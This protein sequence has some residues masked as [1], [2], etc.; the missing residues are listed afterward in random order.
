MISSI[1]GATGAVSEN[2]ELV[3][4]GFGQEVLTCPTAMGGKDWDAGAYSP[5]TNM[6]Y[7]PLR[8]ACA[9]MAPLDD[10]GRSLYSLSMR[11]E[12]APGAD[13]LGGGV[14]D[15]RGDRRDGVDL[16]AARGDDVLPSRL[17]AAGSLRPRTAGRA[18]WQT[19]GR[20]LGSDPGAAHGQ[21]HHR[22]L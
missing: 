18:A 21:E 11:D 16:R 5:L 14:G 1:D 9:R 20:V 6:M 19:A 7:M 17:P 2:P 13:Q 22:L 3:F 4:G 8:N 10:D 15:L 12:L